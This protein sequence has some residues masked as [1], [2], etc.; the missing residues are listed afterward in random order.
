VNSCV[1][2]HRVP[3]ARSVV[4]PQDEIHDVGFKPEKTHPKHDTHVAVPGCTAR[5]AVARTRRDV[6]GRAP[7]G[8]ILRRAPGAIRGAQTAASLMG[9]APKAR[10]TVEFRTA[11]SDTRRCIVPRSAGDRCCLAPSLL[12]RLF[13]RGPPC[14][15][16][17]STATIPCAAF[18][19]VKS[20]TWS[21]AALAGRGC[22]RS[23]PRYHML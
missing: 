5:S 22:V 14:W 12:S 9:L 1:K 4:V 21:N 18:W 19:C 16:Y 20:L 6:A 7:G 3:S 13:W 23:V 11:N 17:A 10:L 2:A 15:T 8:S